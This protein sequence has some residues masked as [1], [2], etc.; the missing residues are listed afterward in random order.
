MVN[1][2][3]AEFLDLLLDLST[4]E[5]DQFILQVVRLL[6]PEMPATLEDA[7]G[8]LATIVETLRS[9]TTLLR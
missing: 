7:R 5:R 4:H 3:E 1:P 6:A 2:D 8:S 9:E